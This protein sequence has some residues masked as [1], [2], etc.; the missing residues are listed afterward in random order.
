MNEYIF[1]PIEA[2]EIESWIPPLLFTISKESF[3]IAPEFI[4]ILNT[5]WTVALGLYLLSAHF[6]V[7]SVCKMCDMAW[8][9]LLSIT[10]LNTFAMW[11]KFKVK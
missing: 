11:N 1:W 10:S 4:G 2:A 3:S 6:K 7:D 5:Y 9:P 8:C